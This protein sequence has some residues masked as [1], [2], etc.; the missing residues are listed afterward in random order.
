MG[1]VSGGVLG[2]ELW[3]EFGLICNGGM[4]PKQMLLGHGPK[5]TPPQYLKTLQWKYYNSGKGELKEQ[6]KQYWIILNNI[7][8]YQTMLAN[9]GKYW[10]IHWT[11]LGYSRYLTI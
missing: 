1:G 6:L 9:I 8:Q 7:G 5:L 3:V 11:I 2:G 10:T 4:H